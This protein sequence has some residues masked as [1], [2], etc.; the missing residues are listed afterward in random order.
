MFLQYQQLQKYLDLMHLAS[1]IFTNALAPNSL[2][3]QLRCECK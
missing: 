1:D 2:L 3:C